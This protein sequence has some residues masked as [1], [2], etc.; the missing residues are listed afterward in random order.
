[1]EFAGSVAELFE[2]QVED[3]P[4]SIAV[5][6]K[7]GDTLTYKALNRAANRLARRLATTGQAGD[8]VAI[9]MR[10][11]CNIFIS[12]LAA[13]KASRI[14]VVLN[15]DDPPARLAQL[16]GDC[17][18]SVLLTT[19]G[20]E[21]LAAKLAGDDVEVARAD[22]PLDRFSPENL[23]EPIRAT[24][25]ACLL[26][27]SG[28]TGE[29]KGVMYPNG[30]LL[31]SADAGS[32]NW[33]LVPDDRVALIVSLWGGL[34]LGVTWNTLLSGGSVHCY[35]AV[36]VGVTGLAGWMNER[37][38]TVY[39]SASSLF[40]NF[41]RTVDSSTSLPHVRLVRLS[42]DAATWDD[43]RAMRQCFPMA[44]MMHGMGNSECGATLA[45]IVLPPDTP[46]G[47][48][49]LPLGW[50]NDRLDVRIVD[51]NDVECPPGKI[52][53]IV[54]RS[55]LLSPGYWRDPEL[56]ARVFFDEPD[57][58]RGY[59]GGDL[60]FV[61]EQG[62]LVHAGRR[63][64]THKIRG[65]R[66]DI[67]EVE[68]SLARIPEVV[69]AATVVAS[70]PDGEVY[71]IGYVVIQPGSSLT[72]EK[73]RMLARGFMPRHLIPSVLVV[74]DALPRAANGKVDRVRLRSLPPPA[75]R[76]GGAAPR[77]DTEGMLVR[78]WEKAFGQS[79][80]G[81]LDDFFD[82]GGDSL[83]AAVIAAGIED[84]TGF[85]VSFKSFFDRSVLSEMAASIDAALEDGPPEG[86]EM[87]LAPMPRD[88]EIPIPPVQM[89]FWRA[90][91]VRHLAKLSLNTSV[92]C[93][94][95]PLDVEIFQASLDAAVARHE[96]LRTR[97]GGG[98]V[99]PVLLVEPP[100]P[101]SLDVIDLSKEEDVDAAVGA[102]L[103]DAAGRH[104]DLT[105]APLVSFILAKTAPEQHLLV[106]PG[107]HI[108]SDAQSF[109]ILF[110]DIARLYEAKRSGT[111]G[112]L[113]PLPVQYADYAAWY[114][115]AWR[116]GGARYRHAFALWKAHFG[117]GEP[118]HGVEAVRRFWR[119]GP[120]EPAQR[121]RWGLDPE[122]SGGL[123]TLARQLSATGYTVR[124]A[125]YAAALAKITDADRVIVRGVFTN[126]RHRAL[127]SMFGLF[128]A[129]VPI[130]IR[131]ERDDSFARLV[132][133]VRD[134]VGDAQEMAESPIDDIVEEL[135]K[136]G[137]E[138]AG[139]PFWI[140]T[141]TPA[142]P[143]RFG[144][145]ELTRRPPPDKEP[146][147][148]AIVLRLNQFQERDGG[149][150][151]FDNRIYAAAGMQEL[152]DTVTA[153]MRTAARNPSMPVGDL[154]DGDAAEATKP[155]RRASAY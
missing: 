124:L 93:I 76:T 123:D 144:G 132:E 105:V 75:M 113:P 35:P 18:P 30:Y 114:H 5:A 141:T 73:L 104:L 89:P 86:H 7:G 136:Q 10:H 54:V 72:P 45:S 90:S 118:V 70:R 100:G 52:G 128:A 106:V 131:C 6:T 58:T 79:G 84:E 68:K 146:R 50:L 155:R 140:H 47:D 12:M 122:T 67:T 138:V 59:R 125:A 53:T 92:F 34:G 3:H 127:E 139:T 94:D 153:V 28:S 1:M 148:G 65:Q 133:H 150:L 97:F 19:E 110:D 51:E 37:R 56:T 57:G 145:L 82:L 121:M 112:A 78:L 61:N 120:A 108:V 88:R 116:K 2:R 66:V 15:P 26:Y 36:E 11:D 16:F 83:I 44:S 24:D 101:A 119:R 109:N 43:F 63:D 42:S 48:G 149:E 129:F 29:P 95:G 117:D 107:H 49:P 46:P 134:R 154:L 85:R 151:T 77:S 55:R 152:L 143:L 96:S 33:G 17:Q 14:M 22:A 111:E 13:F 142:P 135:R 40:R 31:K 39:A 99:R 103:K 80:I 74:L 41:M 60:A 62:H 81:A 71:L 21:S 91:F 102:L 8:R 147:R 38:I 137:V 25:I 32:V 130:P 126:R 9:L 20:C 69:E 23:R 4:R 87:P 27:T 115:Q 98:A 64:A